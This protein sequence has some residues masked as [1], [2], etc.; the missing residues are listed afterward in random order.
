MT[1]CLEIVQSYD[2]HPH[3]T[4]KA[5]HPLLKLWLLQHPCSHENKIWEDTPSQLLCLAAPQLGPIGLR[6]AFLPCQVPTSSSPLPI[7]DHLLTFYCILSPPGISGDCSGKGQQV[8]LPLSICML[9]GSV[10]GAGTN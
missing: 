1:S 7:T 10:P 3:P 4:S 6:P 5:F 2:G 9:H 8:V